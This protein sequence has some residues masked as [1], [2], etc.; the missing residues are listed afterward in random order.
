MYVCFYVSAFDLWSVFSV[1]FFDCLLV[2]CLTISFYTIDCVD[3]L[4]NFVSEMTNKR[5]H[6]DVK[7]CF[8]FIFVVL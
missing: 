8:S 5:V 7:F 3:R 6:R 4:V 2:V 1:Q